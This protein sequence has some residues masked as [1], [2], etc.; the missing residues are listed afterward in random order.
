MAIQIIIPYYKPTKYSVGRAVVACTVT[1]PVYTSTVRQAL[2]DA[3]QKIWKG[4]PVQ[5]I[6]TPASAAMRWTLRAANA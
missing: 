1:D 4:S 6:G 5:S 2:Q 3:T